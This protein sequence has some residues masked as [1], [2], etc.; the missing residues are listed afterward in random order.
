MAQQIITIEITPEGK[1]TVD[2]Q[3]FQGVGCAAVL[4]AF[5]SGDTKLSEISKP[6]FKATRL[7]TVCQ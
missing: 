6:E 3:G 2:L 1:K 4:E 7:T 5:T